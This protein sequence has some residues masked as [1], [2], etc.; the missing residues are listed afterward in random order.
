[1]H[2]DLLHSEKKVFVMEFK[3]DGAIVLYLA[4]KLQVAI[5]RAL[6]YLKVNN[7][8]FL[9]PLLVT[10]ILAVLHHVQKLALM[11][12]TTPEMIRK[13]KTIFDR[14]PRRT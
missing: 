6:Q 10:T 1:M 7:I 11:L 3:R 8:L 14:N 9:V 4:G 13:V 2:F 12:V 5:V